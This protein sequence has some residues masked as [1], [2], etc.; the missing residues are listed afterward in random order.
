MK[1]LYQ[2]LEVSTQATPEEIKRAY[3]VLAKKY[4]PDSNS[5]QGV[6]ERFN[7]ISEAYQILRDEKLRRDYDQAF[8][9]QSS[10]TQR[11]QSQGPRAPRPNTDG[12]DINFE[13]EQFFGFN[14][15]GKKPSEKNQ[16]KKEPMD[17]SRIFD[18][19]FK[20]K[21]D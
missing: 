2:I 15:S 10:K 8:F 12:V 17:T 5:A 6:A 14:P 16:A 13:F 18:S 9:N 21:R 19:F 3:R 11:K 20:V 4:H 7:E 1:N